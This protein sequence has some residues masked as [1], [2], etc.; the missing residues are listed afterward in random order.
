[1]SAEQEVQTSQVKGTEQVLSMWKN[2]EHSESHKEHKRPEGKTKHGQRMTADEVRTGRRR[3]ITRQFYVS[4]RG[5]DFI[6]QARD[7]RRVFCQTPMSPHAPRIKEEKKKGW[8]NWL[9]RDCILHTRLGRFTRHTGRL[10]SL[11][12]STVKSPTFT[13]ELSLTPSFP[14]SFNCGLLCAQRLLICHFSALGNGG[15]QKA[16]NHPLDCV[17]QEDG[18]GGQ[19]K[20]RRGREA[21]LDTGSEEAEAATWWRNQEN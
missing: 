16:R 8:S 18:S 12:I 19:V 21:G 15:W 17:F 7:F 20:D 5:L 3:Q 11:S 6:L 10:Q 9:G 13:V 2:L 1:M 14:N 4:L